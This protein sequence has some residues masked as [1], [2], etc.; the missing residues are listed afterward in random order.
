ML[1]LGVDLYFS[2]SDDDSASMGM[3][4]TASSTDIK[5]QG[6]SIVIPPLAIKEN[7]T[8][9]VDNVVMSPRP[10]NT[11]RGSYIGK[12]SDFT[13]EDVKTLTQMGKTEWV[14]LNYSFTPEAAKAIKEYLRSPV[15]RVQT[16]KFVNCTLDPTFMKEFCKGLKDSKSLSTLQ[17]EGCVL[18]KKIT[19][20]V[21]KALEN[22]AFGLRYLNFINVTIS[23]ETLNELVKGIVAQNTIVRRIIEEELS[24]GKDLSTLFQRV[25]QPLGINMDAYQLTFHDLIK[26]FNQDGIDKIDCFEKLLEGKVG[27]QTLCLEGCRLGSSHGKPIADLIAGSTRLKELNLQGNSLGSSKNIL[28]AQNPKDRLIRKQHPL[29]PSDAIVSIAQALEKNHS[30]TNLILSSNRVSGSDWKILYNVITEVVVDGGKVVSSPRNQSVVINLTNN[31]LEEQLRHSRLILVGSSPRS[32]SSPPELEHS[33]R[34]MF[35]PRTRST[36]AEEAQLEKSIKVKNTR[37]RTD[38]VRRSTFL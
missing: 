8:D 33:P 2:G 32:L 4:P 3:S 19:Y 17:M 16:I 23:S 20:Y 34:L 18:S 29:G 26:V 35:T 15:S 37:R 25:C 12:R 31:Q 14:F 11:P 13:D 36:S 30:L 9:P 5:V 22:G 1:P 10:W 21:R 28:K 38:H 7:V 24:K 27:I 6:A